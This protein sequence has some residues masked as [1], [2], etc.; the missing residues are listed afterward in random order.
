V[1]RSLLRRWLKIYEDE[2]PIFLWT[3]ALMFLVRSSGMILN[4][5]AETAF[6]KRYGVEYLPIVNMINA[7]ATFAVMGVLTALMTRFKDA[8]LLAHL[9]IFCALSVGGL[10]LL[11]P[12]DI[13]LIYPVLFMLK[14][15]YEVLQALLFWN[16][17]NDL[18]NT[19]QSKRIFPLVTAGGVIG[20]ILSSFGTP[21]LAKVLAFD[22]LLWT[23]G[24]LCLLG[25]L[26]VKG[27]GGR[28]PALLLA[29]QQT[30]KTQKR[31]SAFKEI[32]K[33]LPLMKESVLLK[34]LIVLTLMPNVVIPIMNYQFNYAVNEQ[35]ATE[36]A[37][38]QFF[39]YFRGVLNVISL[40]ILLFVG[41]IYGRWGLPVALMFH[42]FNYLLAFLAF[43]FRFDVIS[44]IYAR[45]S[46]NIL[47]TTINTPANA[48][49]MGLFPESYRP[50]VRPFLRGTVVRIGLF[51]GSGL[52]LLSEPLFHPRFLSLVSLPFVLAWVLAPFFLKKRYA[53]ILLDLVARNV[54]DLKSMEEQDVKGLFREKGMRLRLKESFLSAKGKDTLW[55]GRLL[56]SVSA[57]DLDTLILHKIEYQDVETQIGLLAL[58]SPNAG[59]AAEEVFLR[60]VDPQNQPLMEALVHSAKRITNGNFD[61]FLKRAFDRSADAR[62]QA[63]ALGGLYR[64]S[65]DVYRE[66]LNSWLSSGETALRQAGIIAAGKSGDPV[67]RERLVSLLEQD[68]SPS[69]ISDV[70]KGLQELHAPGLNPL[71]QAYL[72]H[73][74][75]KVRLAALE[76]LEVMDEETLVRAVSMMGDADDAIYALAME[77]IAAAPYLNGERLIESLSFSRRR[78]REGIFELLQR[79]NVKGIDT[80]RFVRHQ[81]ETGYQLLMEVQA[82]RRL[83]ESPGR[84]LLIRHKDQEKTVRLQNCL[85]VLALQDAT[86]K[87]KIVVRGVFSTDPR[88]RA[89][90]LEALE[91]LLDAALS[92]MMIP[93]L[94]DADLSQRITVGKK[95]F[96]LKQPPSE[97]RALFSYF[98]AQP[99]WVTTVLVLYLA[100]DFPMETGERE[101]SE[102]SESSDTARARKPSGGTLHRNRRILD[103]RKRVMEGKITIPDKILHLKGIEIFEGLS[104][105]ELAAVASVT[106]EADFPAG[107]IV[108]REGGPGDTMYMIVEGKVVIVKEA[109]TEGE[110]ELDRIGEGDYFGEMALFEDLVRSATV[111]TVEASRL[112]SLHKEEFKEIVREYPEIALHICKVL[113]SRIRKLHEKFKV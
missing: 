21:F 23:Y 91:D 17:A 54:I 106:E 22:N 111:K 55:F 69:L 49:I 71:V 108:I 105:G 87:F 10:R 4:N 94:E 92:K 39:G 58:L 45:M 32:Q 9:F 81:L 90:S 6:L 64:R 31:T 63:C 110:F 66:I 101:L 27:M 79:L 47:R 43:L 7:I 42:P 83:P 100:Q 62:V 12:Y 19:R 80:Y 3:V 51:V 46:T 86:G 36:G 102:T 93:L 15:Q 11:I 113:S 2:I 67:F 61:V 72:S 41:R 107:E 76:V 112:L 104:V 89:N 68:K 98:L 70:L 82:L 30:K 13:D 50:L 73:P 75:G 26:V 1:M 59:E 52:I 14:A 44:A 18:F 48:V 74:S 29:K 34:V 85:R 20:L 56:K 109:G 16:L 77:K 24:G 8:R 78:V 95:H 33:V 65:P 40:I 25:A 96:S 60:M 53:D 88:Q 97:P 99:D 38:I 37:L 84:E 57:E 103:E 5:Y 28:F 35:F